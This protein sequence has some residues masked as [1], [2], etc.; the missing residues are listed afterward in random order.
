MPARKKLRKYELIYIVQPEA[1]DEERQK[2]A[3][4]V[5]D[6]IGRFEGTILQ[7]EDWGKRKLAYEIRKFNK[8]YYQY[9]VFAAYPG[10]TQEIERNLRMLDACIR[11][12]T[13]KLEDEVTPES[14]TAP[15]PSGQSRRPAPE[16]ESEEAGEGESAAPATEEA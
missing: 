6:V 7:D 15:P 11:Y 16:V 8:G 9:F 10:T 2:V 12:M 13:V 14:L 4:R 1:T 5:R 3:D